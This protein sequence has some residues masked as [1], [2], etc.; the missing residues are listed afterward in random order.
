MTGR[1]AVRTARTGERSHMSD[2]HERHEPGS[3]DAPDDDHVGDDPMHPHPQ[4]R[5]S[6][7]PG[8]KDDDSPVERYRDSPG[9]AVADE[10][11]DVV[12]PNEPG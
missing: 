6:K 10:T 8:K 11:S 12:E 7:G 3:K 4:D 1:H 9:L 5:G 2:Q